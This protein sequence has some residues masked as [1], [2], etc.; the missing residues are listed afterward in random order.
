MFEARIEDLTDSIE[1]GALPYLLALTDAVGG[2]VD[3]INAIPGAPQLLGVA[4]VALVL[5]GIVGPLIGLVDGLVFPMIAVGGTAYT[6][7][8]GLF[9]TGD[10]ALAA[11]GAFGSMAV[12]EY[13]AFLPIIA[14]VAGL[15]LL[16]V[17]LYEVEQKTHA[18]SNAWTVFSQSSMGKDLIND[19]QMLVGLLSSGAVDLGGHFLNGAV[20]GVTV[21][22]EVVGGAFEKADGFYKFLKDHDALD[23][24]LGFAIGGPIGAL[25]TGLPLIEAHL[26]PIDSFTKLIYYLI[27]ELLTVYTDFVT[28]I[29]GVWDDIVGAILGIAK[30][31]TDE[32]ER[33]GNWSQGKGYQTNADIAKSQSTGSTTPALNLDTTQMPPGYKTAPGEGDQLIIV[34]PDDKSIGA[35]TYNHLPDNQNPD[36]MKR[37]WDDYYT[38]TQTQKNQTLQRHQHLPQE[39]FSVMRALV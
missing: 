29:K 35:A 26:D 15:V 21:F 1:D 7:A 12:A 33:L 23:V 14:L 19:V 13:A 8:T 38:T 25:I 30:P 20:Q 6:L 5:A 2:L 36:L 16:G 3:V 22:E 9:Y 34:G 32:L 4:A 18:F 10:A 27:R 24:V 17:G 37:A 28:W 39:M 31:I 11:E